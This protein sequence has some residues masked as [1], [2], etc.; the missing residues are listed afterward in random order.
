VDERGVDSI[1]TESLKARF[2]RCTNA[3]A[4]EVEKRR[5]A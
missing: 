3:V 4:A 2:E 1:E 5:I